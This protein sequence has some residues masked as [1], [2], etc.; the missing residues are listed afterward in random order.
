MAAFNR[1]R[2]T[3]AYRP[4][5]RACLHAASFAEAPRPPAARCTRATPQSAQACAAAPGCS[6]GAAC[7]SWRPPDS[8][9]TREREYSSGHCE[10]RAPRCK[11]RCCVVAAAQATQEGTLHGACVAPAGPA[12]RGFAWQTAAWPVAGTGVSA[13]ARQTVSTTGRA[14][15]STLPRDGQLRARSAC[16]ST[17]ALVSSP[18][19]HAGE[20]T[21]C[22]SAPGTRPA[23]RR[24]RPAVPACQRAA[25]LAQLAARRRALGS[26][27]P[28]MAA[29]TRG[30]A[31][32][33]CAAR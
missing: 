12:R 9:S 31:L 15:R 24:R 22:A 8:D 32:L 16:S 1:L 13:R 30:R 27:S 26:A 6:V 28:L 3:K 19:L 5:R 14:L 25:T 4:K 11:Q 2:R 20:A 23:R 33:S 10:A 21:A 29:D 17:H 18:Q 7:A